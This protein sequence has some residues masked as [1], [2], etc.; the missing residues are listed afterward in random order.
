MRA[1][2]VTESNLGFNPHPR[3]E[4]LRF[5]D[6]GYCCVV[7]DLL[8]QPAYFRSVATV[9]ARW[10][11]ALFYSGALLTAARSVL[12]TA[13]QAILSPAASL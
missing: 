11:R 10:N 13:S 3:V 2:A 9:Q 8:L 1:G 12:R 5:G 7:D 6:G 4:V